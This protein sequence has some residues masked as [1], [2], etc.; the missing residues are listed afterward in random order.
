LPERLHE[1]SATG[2][3]ALIQETDAVNFPQLLRLGCHFNSKQC[4]GNK[5]LT[6][7]P[8]FFKTHLVREGVI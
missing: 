2:S 3:S 5:E 6:D 7:Q 8:I 4:H 1:D